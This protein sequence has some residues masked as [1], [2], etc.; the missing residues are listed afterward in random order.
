[1]EKR[2]AKRQV[3]RQAGMA[4]GTRVGEAGGCNIHGGPVDAPRPG[5]HD[6][7]GDDADCIESQKLRKRFK[8]QKLI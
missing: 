7:G 8:G 6:F 2:E 3:K 4:G 1:M 5:K